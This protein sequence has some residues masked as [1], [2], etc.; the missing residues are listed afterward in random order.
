M[1]SE[2]LENRILISSEKTVRDTL[3]I[4]VIIDK[5]SAVPRALPL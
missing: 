3:K 1:A 5:F 2:C 4:H